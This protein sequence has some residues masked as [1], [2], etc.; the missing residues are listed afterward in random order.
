MCCFPLKPPK[1]YRWAAR[2]LTWHC[3]MIQEMIDECLNK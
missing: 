3:D 2:K 1:R